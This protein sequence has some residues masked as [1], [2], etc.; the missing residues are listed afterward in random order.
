MKGMFITLKLNEWALA[1][2]I[3]ELREKIAAL[4]FASVEAA[5]LPAFRQEIGVVARC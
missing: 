4:G 5:A 3:P 1:E 2:R